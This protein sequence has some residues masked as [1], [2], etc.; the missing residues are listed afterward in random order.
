[1]DLG[2]HAHVLVPEHDPRLR[3]G[4]PLVH[5]QVGAADRGSGDLDDHV[6]RVLDPRVVDGRHLDPVRFSV[7]DGLH[8]GRRYRA[9]A[10]WRANCSTNVLMNAGR[11]AGLRLLTITLGCSLTTT[12][13]ST[14]SPPALPMSVRRLGH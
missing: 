1:A 3:A 4:P 12:S 13:R 6:G 14:H 11:S 2:H 7:D 8:G 10:A 9:P 5:V